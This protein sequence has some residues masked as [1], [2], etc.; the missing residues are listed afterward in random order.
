MW[1][2]AQTTVPPLR[3]P[4]TVEAEVTGVAG[5]D[6]R[7]VAD[8]PRAE[9]RRRRVGHPVGEREGV[10]LVGDRVLGVAAVHAVPREAR[11]R[12]QVL[13]PRPAVAALAARPRQPW[14]ADA[15]AR[16]EA[17][18]TVAS[19]GHGADDLVAEHQ[20]Q[21]RVRELAVGDVEVGAA[22]PTGVHAQQELARAR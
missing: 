6:E 12:A 11:P 5:G 4:E 8:E 17:L 15:A 13:A 9:E 22:D 21:L 1:M 2:P 19:L 3:G 18:G 16:R 20:R 14:H 10:P 7:A